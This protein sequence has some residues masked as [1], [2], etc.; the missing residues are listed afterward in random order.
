[1]SD[2]GVVAT[3]AVGFGLRLSKFTTGLG[4]VGAGFCPDAIGFAVTEVSTFSKA[5][6][7]WMTVASEA[8]KGSS[9][10]SSSP[11]PKSSV[12]AAPLGVVSTTAIAVVGSGPNEGSEAGGESVEPS[13]LPQSLASQSSASAVFEAGITG[14]IS[15]SFSLV[16]EIVEDGTVEAGMAAGAASAEEIVFSTVEAGAGTAG[17]G[18]GDGTSFSLSQSENEGLILEGL[19]TDGAK[20]DRVVAETSVAYC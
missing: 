9:S 10:L 8:E 18:A 12:G 4:G 15:F 3:T 17:V 1:M 11:Q 6:V 5:G 2:A 16:S 13:S 7:C 19:T 14:A 20:S